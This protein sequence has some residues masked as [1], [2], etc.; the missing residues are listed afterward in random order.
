M[1]S[2]RV[3]SASS[4]RAQKRHAPV[5]IPV[6]VHGNHPNFAPSPQLLYISI[7]KLVSDFLLKDNA[8]TTGEILQ[9]NIA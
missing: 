2:C 1:N 3:V 9:K 7:Y 6:N 8:R 5:P 4:A